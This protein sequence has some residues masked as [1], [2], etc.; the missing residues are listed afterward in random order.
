M[1]FDILF[2]DD[3]LYHNFEDVFEIIP[4]TKAI[5]TRCKKN[6]FEIIT[7]NSFVRATRRT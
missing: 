5:Y 4:D 3:N 2:D 7:K 6:P 1:D